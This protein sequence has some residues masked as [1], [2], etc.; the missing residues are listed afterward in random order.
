MTTYAPEIVYF[1]R[2]QELRTGTAQLFEEVK[3]RLKRL[4]PGAEIQHVGSTA[5]PGSLTK[6]DLDIQVRVAQ[7]EY[8]D[9]KTTLLAIYQI[10]SGGFDAD[11]GASFGDYSTRPP[12]GVHLTVIGGSCDIQWRFRDALLSSSELRREYDGLK[13]R[14]HGKEM[15][16]YRDAKAQFADKVEQSAAY[17]ATAGSD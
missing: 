5:I 8:E 16:A 13:R 7:H 2:E 1:V 3:A 10:N 4:L 6:G 12:H 11:D 15:E 9:A 14:F 17:A